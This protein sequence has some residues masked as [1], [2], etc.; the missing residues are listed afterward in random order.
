MAAEVRA[1]VAA[2]LL[3]APA[4]VQPNQLE[5]NAPNLQSPV[6][7]YSVTSCRNQRQCQRSPSH[8]AR[9]PDSEMSCAFK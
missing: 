3:A 6:Q 8:Q 1:A 9:C 5:N 7:R 4:L 2:P